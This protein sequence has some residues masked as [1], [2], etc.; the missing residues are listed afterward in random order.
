MKLYKKT[1]IFIFLFSFSISSFSQSITVVDS[2]INRLKS[3]KDDTSKALLYDE[4]MWNLLFASPDSALYYFE[5][6][7]KLSEKLNYHNGL[8]HAYKLQGNTLYN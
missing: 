2:L 3:M 4:I 5:K 8:A 6:G 7:V 1:L